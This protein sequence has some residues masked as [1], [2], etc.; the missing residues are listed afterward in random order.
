MLMYVYVCMPVYVCVRA[1]VCVCVCVCVCVRACKCTHAL[2]EKL[3][4][5]YICIE[6]TSVLDRVDNYSQI[7]PDYIDFRLKLFSSMSTK[8]PR[9]IWAFRS[10]CSL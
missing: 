2:L 4:F 9:F 10:L 3:Q 5:Q 7:H 1:R 6:S 8:L